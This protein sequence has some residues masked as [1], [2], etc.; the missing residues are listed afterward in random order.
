MG[1]GLLTKKG[2]RMMDKKNKESIY[3]CITMAM[4]IILLIGF[5]T[6][7]K[8]CGSDPTNGKMP[9]GSYVTVKLD[10]RRGQV[11]TYSCGKVVVRVPTA[12][13]YSIWNFKPEDLEV[14]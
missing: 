4:L 5:L 10:G 8:S 3:T 2:L 9:I 12:N 11:R 1:L 7:I 14:E 6:V 13:G